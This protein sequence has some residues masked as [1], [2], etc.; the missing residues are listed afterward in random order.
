MVAKE[1]RDGWWKFAIGVLLFAIVVANLL[2]Y[3]VILQDTLNPPL[4]GPDGSPIPEEFTE[5]TNPVE[6]ALSEMWFSYGFSGTWIMFTLATFLGF[7]IVS[8]E[9]SRS[10]IFL[11]LARP[12]SRT[13]M[14]LTKYGVLAGGLLAVFALGALG[15]IVSAGLKG[16]PLGELSVAGLFLS[17]TLLWLGSLSVLGL[18]TLA[19]VVFRDVI[20]SAIATPL[21]LVLIFFLP[22][23]FVSYFSQ[24]VAR[25]AEAA[26]QWGEKLLLPIYWTSESLFMGESLAATNFLV[27]AIAAGI[28]L[29]AALWLFNRKAY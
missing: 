21:V 3:E 6:Y 25:S 22:G 28:P 13:R 7:S 23:I 11:L 12:V 10:S 4:V 5:P 20:A 24:E 15:L 9:A 16:Y 18:A 17:V 2:P 26:G 1:L 29:L 19:S 27:C 8:G 14:L